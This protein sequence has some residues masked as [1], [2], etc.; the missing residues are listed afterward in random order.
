MTIQEFIKYN[1]CSQMPCHDIGQGMGYKEDISKWDEVN[2][3]D[4]IYIP[5]SAYEDGRVLRQ[6]AFSK[7][8]LVLMVKD[9]IDRVGIEQFKEKTHKEE[10]ADLYEFLAKDLFCALDWQY[11]S[12]MIDEGWLDEYASEGVCH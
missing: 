4:I 7:E 1:G 3:G 6:N 11:P 8:D 9:Y 2:N 10:K 12:S 5:E